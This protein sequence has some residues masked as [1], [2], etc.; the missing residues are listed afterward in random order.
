MQLRRRLLTGGLFFLQYVS[1]SRIFKQTLRHRRLSSR[2]LDQSVRSTVRSTST[3]ERERCWTQG[4]G[5]GWIGLLQEH[6]RYAFW[7]ENQIHLWLEQGI[8]LLICMLITVHMHL[9]STVPSTYTSSTCC[10]STFVAGLFEYHTCMY[11][12]ELQVELGR[13][14]IRGDDRKRELA[15]SSFF[16]PFNR[17]CQ[18]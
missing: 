4:G 9:W 18:V 5:D 8:D 6:G 14:L 17:V 11:T 12:L 7:K 10:V 16:Y 15:C 3:A 13:S 2:T 1:A